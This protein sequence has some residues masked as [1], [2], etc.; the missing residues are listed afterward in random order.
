MLVSSEKIE[1]KLK[2]CATP[3]DCYSMR[4]ASKDACELEA[5]GYRCVHCCTD[6]LC[7]DGGFI[8]DGND[9][10]EQPDYSANAILSEPEPESEAGIS[11]MR[12][13]LVLFMLIELTAIE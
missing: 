13:N 2:V 3:K 11:Q 4:V 10:F 1:K 9:A 12:V 6:S 7:N 8:P 5:D